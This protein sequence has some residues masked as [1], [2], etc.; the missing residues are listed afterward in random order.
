MK[1]TTTPKTRAHAEFII[2]GGF[3]HLSI[4]SDDHLTEQQI[5][6]AVS[7]YFSNPDFHVA[8]FTWESNG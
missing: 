4:T 1:S 3:G 5:K 6:E 7:A 2:P 8:Y